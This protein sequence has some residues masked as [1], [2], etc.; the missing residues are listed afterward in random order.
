MVLNVV[1]TLFGQPESEKFFFHGHQN[2]ILG[3]EFEI[4]QVMLQ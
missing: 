2:E 3:E 4:K 1:V